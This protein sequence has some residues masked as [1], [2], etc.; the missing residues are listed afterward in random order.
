MGY[1]GHSMSE[2]AAEAYGAGEAPLSKWNKLRLT[3]MVCTAD[4][5]EWTPEELRG[6]TVHDLRRHFLAY[7]GWHHTGRFYNRTAF[8][9]IDE[10]AIR[11]H[12][13]QGLQRRA[14]EARADRAE[15]DREAHVLAKGRIAWD[16]WEGSRRYGRFVRREEPCLIVG[17]WA[18]TEGGKKRL[19]GEHVVDYEVFERAPRGTAASYR[20]IESALPKSLRSR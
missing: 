15:A 8:F 2:R 17:N 10:E 16:E 6:A 19:D 3:Q 5:S 4:G 9:G 20:R 14:R 7:T 12:D 11:L 13:V 18:Y 1:I